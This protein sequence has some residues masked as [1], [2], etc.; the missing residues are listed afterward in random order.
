MLYRFNEMYSQVIGK[1]LWYFSVWDS[2]QKVWRLFIHCDNSLVVDM[3]ELFNW[4]VVLVYADLVLYTNNADFHTR[5]TGTNQGCYMDIGIGIRFT[6][7]NFKIYRILQTSLETPCHMPQ[8]HCP[9]STLE[10][11]RM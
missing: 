1:P 9:E 6:S 7:E 2:H 11:G 10:R 3:A 5:K 8:S 4:Y